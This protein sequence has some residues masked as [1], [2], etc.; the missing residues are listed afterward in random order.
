[1]PQDCENHNRK[2]MVTRGV[3][4][5]AMA[6]RA[7]R[8]SVV[9]T[10]RQTVAMAAMGIMGSMTRNSEQVS[11]NLGASKLEAKGRMAQCAVKKSASASRASKAVARAITL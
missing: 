8:S 7:N 6:G 4:A 9:K 10:D 1:M 11:A 3:A 5:G 2:A